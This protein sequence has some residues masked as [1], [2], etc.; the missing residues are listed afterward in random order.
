MRG[1][2]A[3]KGLIE[4]NQVNIFIQKSRRKWS[5]ETLAELY[6]G[7]FSLRIKQRL[8][9]FR[10]STFTTTRT[11]FIFHLKTYWC[12]HRVIIAIIVT[13]NLL[14]W[15]QNGHQR[16]YDVIFV[17]KTSKSSSQNMNKEQRFWIKKIF[18]KYLFLCTFFDFCQTGKD[19][20]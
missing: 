3:V 5:T 18:E 15:K 10:K 8:Q 20:S 17:F 7:W 16:A 14:S 4:C 13:Q 11:I 19:I 9:W 1:A 6:E 12:S 2:L